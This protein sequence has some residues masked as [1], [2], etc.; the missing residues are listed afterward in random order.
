MGLGRALSPRYT[1]YML[2]TW[3]QAYCLNL[4]GVLSVGLMLGIIHGAKAHK[5]LGTHLHM[6]QKGVWCG[7]YI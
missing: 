1:G 2:S 6:S 3:A 4:Y 7:L 5:A